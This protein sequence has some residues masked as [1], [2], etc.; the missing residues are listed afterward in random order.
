MKQILHNKH[1]LQ[2]VPEGQNYFDIYGSD[3]N[4]EVVYYKM[5]RPVKFEKV[6]IPL[7]PGSW[8]ILC[9]A[10][11]ATPDIAR[12]IVEMKKTFGYRKYDAVS[13]EFQWTNEVESLYSLIRSHG[14]QVTETIILLNNQK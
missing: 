7:P 2:Q 6:S 10:S 12:E 9:K 11:D 5:V 13:G 4:R 3:V 8:Q 1:L 14:M